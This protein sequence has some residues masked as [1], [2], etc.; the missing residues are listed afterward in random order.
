MEDAVFQPP[1]ELLERPSTYVIQDRSQQEEIVRLELQDT[2]LTLGTGGV[3][4]EL[5]YPTRLRRVLDVGCG[6]G[7]WLIE[8]ATRYPTIE[9]L[10]GV[11]ISR[12]MVR[13]ARQ[14][15]CAAHVNDRARFQTMDALGMLDFQT[16]SFD[17]VNQRLGLS[18]LRTWD[19]Q[20]LLLQYGRVT[21]PGGIIRLTEINVAWETNSPALTQ[22]NTIIIDA[23]HRSGHLFTP[24]GDGVTARLVQ[25]M[26]KHDIQDVKSCVSTLAYQPGTRLG[27]YFYED[28][29]IGLRTGLPFFQKWTHVPSNYQGIYQ[30]ALK[31]MQ[32]PE[33]AATWTWLTAWGTTPER[34]DY[35]PKTR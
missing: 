31:E 24:S 20:K 28:I 29:V 12:T 1:E 2:L 10:V 27:Q 23:L 5:D 21:R 11:D 9:A 6:T 8:T 7:G 30:Q 15:A 22:L 33:F 19:W 34:Y 25:L 17:L 14:K 18:W 13:R 32:A 35:N 4:P 3:L 26:T 16:S